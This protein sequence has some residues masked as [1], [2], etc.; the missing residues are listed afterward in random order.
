[1]GQLVGDG[2]TP[3]TA[4]CG[5]ITNAQ[6]WTLAYNA[7]IIYVG[8]TGNEDL[9]V[10]TGGFLTIQAGVTVMFCTTGSDLIITSSGKLTAIGSGASN[11]TFTKNLQATWGHIKMNGTGSCQLSYST[12]EW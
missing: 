8:Q 3:A 12:I 1:M 2:L 7:G 11:I 10:T 5:T 6:S 9:T 4:Y